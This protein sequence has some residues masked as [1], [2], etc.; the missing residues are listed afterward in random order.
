MNNGFLALGI[1]RGTG[2]T[3]RPGFRTDRALPVRFGQEQVV[4]VPKLIPQ[5]SRNPRTPARFEGSRLELGLG[6][7][8]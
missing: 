3:V 7:R 1:L 6:F 5:E 2:R 8:V 4:R